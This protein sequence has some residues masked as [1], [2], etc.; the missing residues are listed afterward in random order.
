MRQIESNGS[1][2]GGVAI[3]GI[4]APTENVGADESSGDGDPIRIGFRESGAG[5]C[6][7]FQQIKCGNGGPIAA[8]AEL[9]AKIDFDNTEDLGLRIEQ[10][11]E[12]TGA[13]TR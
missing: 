6:G 1:V 4:D 9:A 5:V 8:I 13:V 10:A 3:Q 12:I 11:G 2:D 7:R